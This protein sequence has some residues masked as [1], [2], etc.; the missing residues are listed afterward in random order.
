MLT[1]VQ[2]F[3]EPRFPSVILAIALWLFSLASS[4]QDVDA[5]SH[6]VVK[7]ESVASDGQ[8]RTG[9]GFVVRLEG[10]VAYILTAYHV[11]KGDKNPAVTFFDRQRDPVRSEVMEND[12]ALDVSLL[13]VRGRTSIP[14]STRSIALAQSDD[15]RSLE[16]VVAIGFPAFLGDWAPID[17]K[18]ATKK[19]K[20]V[21]FLGAIPA[22]S[23]GGP[24]IRQA[25]VVAMTTDEGPSAGQG[26]RATFLRGL[27][28]GW[29]I[30][31][32]DSG[33]APVVTD[34]YPPG[35][36]FEDCSGCPRMVVVP[37]GSFVMGSPSDEPYRGEDEGP[38]RPVQVKKFA[39]GRTE[40]TR[41]EFRRFVR[42]TGRSVS[43]CY[44][45]D[46]E[47]WKL[48][49]RK[50]WES[51]GYDQTDDHPAVCLDWND[52]QAYVQWLSKRSGE[53]YRLASEAEWEYGV[54]AGSRGVRYWGNGEADTCRFANIA[55]QAGKRKYNWGARPVGC[56]DGYANTAPVGS[57]RSNDFGLYDMLGNVWEWTEDCWNKSYRGAPTSGQAWTSG[58]C[59]LRVVRGG[60]WS[61]R[62]QDTRS[63]LR[64]GNGSTNRDSFLGIRVAR[65][66]P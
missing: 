56:D 48:N 59:S 40:V 12:S 39:L 57:Y 30:A 22:G 6:G 3:R 36:E 23:S 64:N 46:G 13:V 33:G 50:N 41:G 49:A 53:T 19:G 38:Q 31:L 28:S 51:P 42:D 63:A 2:P 5:L 52:A 29:K 10:E 9:A 62:P 60:S 45:Y 24:V 65:T 15:F 61:D 11:V 27:A 44:V 8:K 20:H 54:R 4:A 14:V 66:L 35:K 21:T 26:I 17:L 25:V 58:D 43:G 37:G 55:D 18:V 7:I 34:P 1:V 47:E 32:D 16:P